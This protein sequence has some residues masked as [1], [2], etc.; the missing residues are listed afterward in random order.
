MAV[1]A[2]NSKKHEVRDRIACLEA[3][4]RYAAALGYEVT[5]VK[6]ATADYSDV[7]MHAALEVN[8]PNYANAIVTTSEAVESI[9]A[10]D[11]L[12]IEPVRNLA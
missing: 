12:G 6:D 3:T 1:I 8:L 5:V 9:S 4:V 2:E 11:A 10:L 7:E